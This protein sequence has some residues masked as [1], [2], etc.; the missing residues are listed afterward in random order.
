MRAPHAATCDCDRCCE[1]Q[2]RPLSPALQAEV[3]AIP[4][5]EVEEFAKACA[6]PIDQPR[7]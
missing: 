7:E 2:D 1:K 6:P 5:G 4:A 3:D